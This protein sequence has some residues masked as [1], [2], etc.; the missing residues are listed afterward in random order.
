MDSIHY[1]GDIV[2]QKVAAKESLDKK[3][4]REKSSTKR[5]KIKI[6]REA[7][8]DELA[9]AKAE[10]EKA[11]EETKLAREEAKQLLE[12]LQA[13]KDGVNK[14]SKEGKK[15]STQGTS[16]SDATPRSIEHVQD[17]EHLSC[18][19]EL[20]GG[21]P[22]E[23]KEE[24]DR[25]EDDDSVLEWSGDRPNQ[26][27][28]CGGVEFDDMVKGLMCCFMDDDDIIAAGV[29]KQKK[30]RRSKSRKKSRRS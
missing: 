2:N 19:S 9:A 20:T 16:K 12:E 17:E 22:E 25:D 18:M 4:R 21:L 11:E 10:A 14:N 5:A 30:R 3:L 8:N 26:S 7:A 24:E 27:G 15:T 6:Q 13:V 23:E 28:L 29:K 1:I